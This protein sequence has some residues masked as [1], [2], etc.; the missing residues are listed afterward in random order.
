MPSFDTEWNIFYTC[1]LTLDQFTVTKP[2]VSPEGGRPLVV[3][4]KCK[5]GGKNE[6]DPLKDNLILLLSVATNGLIEDERGCD[7][8][9]VYSWG[10]RD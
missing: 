6:N 8:Y 2:L 9:I 5:V 4:V 7:C 1:D 10:G 3:P